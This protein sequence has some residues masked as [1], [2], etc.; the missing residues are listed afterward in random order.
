M[1]FFLS[2]FI[3]IVL[4][5]WLFRLLFPILMP[6]VLRW[7]VKRMNGRTN[8]VHHFGG[9]GFA[10]QE[11]EVPIENEKIVGNDIGEYVDFE[12]VDKK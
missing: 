6:F 9:R 11:P 8:F 2:L 7:L 5:V 4:F 10:Q 1:E 12:E 3:G